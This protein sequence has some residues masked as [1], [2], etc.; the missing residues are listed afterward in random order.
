MMKLI[1][2]SFFLL[3]VLSAVKAEE[4]TVNWDFSMSPLLEKKVEP[5]E[6]KNKKRGSFWSWFK[7]KGEVEEVKNSTD[8]EMEDTLVE[9][10]DAS[11][12]EE[13]SPQKKVF[14]I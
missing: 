14:L 12:T 3:S 9:L 7:K 4:E 5:I 8:K 10:E 11:P 2:V 13:Q 1:Y 6:D